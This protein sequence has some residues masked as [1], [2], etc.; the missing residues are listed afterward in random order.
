MPLIGPGRNIANNRAARKRY[1][2][3]NKEYLSYDSIV[4]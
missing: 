4:K 2:A 1:G 3:V